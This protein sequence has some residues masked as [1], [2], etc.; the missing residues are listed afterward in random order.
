VSSLQEITVFRIPEVRLN[1]R[2][3]LRWS[4][5]TVSPSELMGV[6]SSCV[7]LYLTADYVLYAYQNP[8]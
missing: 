3:R 7:L 4:I 2:R 5:L 1:I 8:C 6:V